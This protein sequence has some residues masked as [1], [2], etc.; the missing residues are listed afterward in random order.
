MKKILVAYATMTGSTA[1]VAQ[2]VGAEIAKSGAQVDI[3]P[4]ADVKDIETYAGVV[5]GGPM[6][7]G[8]HRAAL[9]FLK[10]HR[11]AFQRLPVALFVT[12]MS[13]TQ[14]GE[15]SVGGL[16]VYVDEKLP[17]APV[18]A[19]KLTFRERYARLP[20]YIQPMLRAVRPAKP[21]SLAIFGGRLEYGRLPWWGVMFV[22]LVIQAPARDLRN[23]EA[24]SHSQRTQQRSAQRVFFTRWY[25]AGIQFQG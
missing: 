12:A 22:M 18:Q 9:G 15:R 21:V 7:M 11:R 8:W 2:A 16:P 17:K 6:I 20:N 5:I 13:L 19:G 25:P 3:L 14:T 23:W 24:V 4:L 10:K 1:E